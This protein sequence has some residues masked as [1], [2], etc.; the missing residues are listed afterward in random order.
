MLWSALSGRREGMDGAV[1]GSAGDRTRGIAILVAPAF[2][3]Y[4]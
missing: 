4:T 3:F 1:V 2:R